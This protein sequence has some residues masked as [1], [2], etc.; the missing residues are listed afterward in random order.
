MMFLA[1]LKVTKDNKQFKNFK[2]RYHQVQN[3]KA[4]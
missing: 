1:M 3:P 2:A 4:Q